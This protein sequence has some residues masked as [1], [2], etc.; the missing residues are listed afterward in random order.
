[1]A[2]NLSPSP[3]PSG[4]IEEVVVFAGRNRRGRGISPSPDSIVSPEITR[5]AVAIQDEVGS[6]S[7][8][9]HQDSSQSSGLMA[10]REAIPAL[11]E[12]ESHQRYKGGG[13]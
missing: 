1:M 3:T 8:N 7:L 11:H 10:S 2:Q 5:E 9:I 13:P 12:D 6:Q 4:S